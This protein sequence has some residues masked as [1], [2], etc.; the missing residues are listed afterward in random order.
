MGRV[1]R[2][3]PLI[4]MNPLTDVVPWNT[5]VFVLRV[6]AKGGYHTL[7]AAKTH[8]GIT[9]DDFGWHTPFS[10]EAAAQRICRVGINIAK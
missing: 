6:D 10:E 7:D 1:R 2:C 8:L 3:N 4:R 9:G 5:C